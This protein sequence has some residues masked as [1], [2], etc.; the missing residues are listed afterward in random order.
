[1]CTGASPSAP[2]EVD[3][4]PVTDVAATPVATGVCQLSCVP[5]MKSILVGLFGVR[6][7]FVWYV[8]EMMDEMSAAMSCVVPF[9]FLVLDSCAENLTM[10]V[11]CVGTG[12]K[13]FMFMLLAMSY[14][15]HRADTCIL[16]T[17]SCRAMLPF[18]CW[19]RCGSSILWCAGGSLLS[20]TDAKVVL[21]DTS[22]GFAVCTCVAFFW[23]PLFCCGILHVC[24]S[25]AEAAS[26]DAGPG[27]NG[28]DGDGCAGGGRR[29]GGRHGG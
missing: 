16:E 6:L 1:M 20:S 8:L 7:R 12:R 13:F 29:G 17:W 10:V 4:A 9:V 19:E 25:C 24:R 18:S 28:G 3:A 15:M 2:Q 5:F 21:F 14:F 27:G 23:L 11:V 22:C 26:A